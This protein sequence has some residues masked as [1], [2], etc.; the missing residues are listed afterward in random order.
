MK[1]EYLNFHVAELSKACVSGRS[2]VGIVVGSNP[3][4][5]MDICLCECC[6]LSGGGQADHSSRVVLQSVMCAMI[7]ITKSR[8]GR[9]WPGIGVGS[10]WR[11]NKFTFS[12]CYCIAVIEE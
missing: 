6:V 10:P 11:K 12:F 9:P 1:S 8:K 5:D 3:A 4:G 2:L 7:L